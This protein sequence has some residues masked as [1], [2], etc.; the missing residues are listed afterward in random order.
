MLFEWMYCAVTLKNIIN[1]LRYTNKNKQLF[2]IK[3]NK[4]RTH[5]VISFTNLHDLDFSLRKR[6]GK[7][8]YLFRSL[9]R[10]ASEHE[11]LARASC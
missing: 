3:Y 9:A 11:V 4:K 5:I 6:C 10:G 2:L 7:N 8:S 1:I